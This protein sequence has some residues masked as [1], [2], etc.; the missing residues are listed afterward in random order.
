M[1]TDPDYIALRRLHESSNIALAEVIAKNEELLK[2]VTL[3]NAK[4]IN[5][6]RAL[7]INKEIMRNALNEQNKVKDE[8][9]TE[10]SGLR[11]K[12]KALNGNLD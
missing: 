12:V 4:L 7:D 1:L 8:Y 9:S 10:I 5:C 3:L 2:E 11:D 6:Q